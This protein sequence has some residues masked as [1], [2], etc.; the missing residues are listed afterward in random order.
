M[1]ARAHFARVARR[2]GKGASSKSYPAVERM[3]QSDDAKERSRLHGEK[4]AHM[5]WTIGV[6]VPKNERMKRFVVKPRS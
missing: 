3:M 6:G 4:K 1:K 5:D 2:S